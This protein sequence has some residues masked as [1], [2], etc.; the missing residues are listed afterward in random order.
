MESGKYQNE[1]QLEVR[2][3]ECDL[4]GVVN[5]ANYQHY[6][7]HARHKWLEALGIDFA[8]LHKEGV[9]LVAVRIEIDYKYPLHSRDRFVVRSNIKREGRLKLIFYQDIY[10][11]PDDKLIA[12]SRVVATALEN[13]RP[14]IPEIVLEKMKDV[15]SES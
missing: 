7:E 1:L 9:D 11:V 5:N 10:R 6:T 2:D 12:Q 3:Y 14:K 15:L 4:Q 8:A 13:G